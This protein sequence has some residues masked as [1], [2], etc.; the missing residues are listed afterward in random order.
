VVW[1]VKLAFT[2]ATF[3]LLHRSHTAVVHLRSVL[4]LFHLHWPCWWSLCAGAGDPTP[5]AGILWWDGYAHGVWYEV[6]SVYSLYVVI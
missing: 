5:A 1:S 6:Y 4:Q 2:S 3:H